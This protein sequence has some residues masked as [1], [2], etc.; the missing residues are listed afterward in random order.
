MR[1]RARGSWKGGECERRCDPYLGRSP[2]DAALRPRRLHARRTCASKRRESSEA[3]TH[4]KW[5]RV[6]GRSARAE[7]QGERIRALT[8]DMRRGARCGRRAR[9]AP[10]PYLFLSLD[11]VPQPARAH[12]KAEEDGSLGA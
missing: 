6:D 7:D 2:R 4:A 11:G 8:H 5:V 12:G 10:T 3:H 1:S 9:L